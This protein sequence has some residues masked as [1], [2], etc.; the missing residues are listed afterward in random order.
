VE[1]RKPS[2]VLALLA[3]LSRKMSWVGNKV[4]PPPIDS[5]PLGV[6]E[7]KEHKQRE[8]F[9]DDLEKHPL[10]RHDACVMFDSKPI[11]PKDE[12]ESI[13]RDTGC[14]ILNDFAAIAPSFAEG[15]ESSFDFKTGLMKKIPPPLPPRKLK[16]SGSKRL[17]RQVSQI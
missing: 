9:D 13:H 7:E 10:Q 12:E 4:M 5:I 16:K 14:K 8:A 2:G 17:D 6:G 1:H 11:A 3:R 15:E